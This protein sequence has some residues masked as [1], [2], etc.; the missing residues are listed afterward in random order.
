LIDTPSS[1]TGHL[2]S[3]AVH[4]RLVPSPAESTVGEECRVEAV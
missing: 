1:T 3:A 2:G 4:V